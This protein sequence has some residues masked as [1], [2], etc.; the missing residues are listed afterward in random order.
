VQ[1]IRREKGNMPA[2]QRLLELALKGLEADRRKIEDEIVQ[3]KRQLKN[4]GRAGERKG[5]SVAATAVGR[6]RRRMSLAAR[7]RISDGMKRRHAALRASTEKPA[8]KP[9]RTGRITAAGRKR[10]S[11][12]M[13]ARWAAKRKAVKKVA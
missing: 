13:K 7:K 11:E 12:M 2:T 1:D 8:A 9:P 10:I 3:I 4:G 5:M 6:K